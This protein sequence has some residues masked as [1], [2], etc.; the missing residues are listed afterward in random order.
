M[1]IAGDGPE[2]SPLECLALELGVADRVRFLGNWIDVPAL[3]RSVDL[4]VLA[5]KFEPF[6]VA[7]LEAKAAGLP[8]VATAVNEIPKIVAD[9]TSGVLTPPED[10]ASMASLFVRLAEDRDYRV[11]LGRHARLEAQRHDLRAAVTAYESLY[12]ES[13]SNRRTS[14]P[15]YRSVIDRS[16]RRL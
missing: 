11:A 9:G 7:L 14:F 15:S 16:L 4:F 12:D 10:A 1:V 8:I 5:S 6:G 2:R 3:L 13:R